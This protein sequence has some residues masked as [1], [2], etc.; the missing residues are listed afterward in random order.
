M[1]PREL[2]QRVDVSLSPGIQLDVIRVEEVADGCSTSEPVSK[3]TLCDDVAE[4]V[5]AHAQK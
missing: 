2:Y 5:Q 3:A 4:G 1:Y